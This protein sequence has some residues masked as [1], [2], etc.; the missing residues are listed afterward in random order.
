MALYAPDDAWQKYAALGIVGKTRE[1]LQGLSSFPGH[2]AAFY[3]AVTRWINGEDEE[4]SAPRCS[5]GKP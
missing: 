5:P 4:A 2:E 3:A 1:A